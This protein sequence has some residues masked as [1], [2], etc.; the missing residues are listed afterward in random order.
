[1][2]GSPNLIKPPE[3]QIPVTRGIDRHHLRWVEITIWLLAIV[4]GFFYAWANHHYLTNSDAMSYL[5]V[6]EAYLRRDWHAAVNAYWSPLYSW[7]IAL[8]LLIVRP[9]PYWK[10]AVLHLVNFAIYLFALSC[11]SFLIREMLRR[12]RSQSAEILAAG[13]VTLPDWALLTLGYS[14]FIWSSLLLI[15]VPVESPDMLVASFVYLATGIVL[16]IRR[17][18][19]DWLPFF[20]LGMVL[21]FGYLG[22]S[23]M[24]PMALVFV[25]SGILAIGSW[26]RA[27]SRVSITVALFLLLA[28]P[29]VFAISR[30]K[31]RLTTGESGRLN[32]LWAINRVPYF[33][34]QGEEPG[35]GVPRHP[36]RKIFDDPPAYEFGEPVGGTY[37]VW[38][39]P[40]YWYEGSVGHF[41]LRQQLRALVGSVNGYFELFYSRGLQY[42]LLI[43]LVT[44]YLMGRKPRLLL[45]DLTREWSLL[46]P[47]LAGLGLYTLVNVQG[48]YV[49]SFIV[50]LWL[51]L[52]SAVRLPHARDSEKLIKSITLVATISIILTTIMSSTQEAILTGRHL[53]T[54]ENPSVHEQWQVAEGLKEI[55]LG[56]S[57]KVAFVGNSFRAFWA[58]LLG[59]RI[60][61]EIRR[62][63]VD[64]FWQAD[65]SLKGEVINA[66]A[67]T[68]A[69][70]IVFEAPPSGTHLS[71]WQKI[72][73]TNYY[74]YMLKP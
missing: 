37:P 32:Y 44:L 6:A 18:P 23:I 63:R 39:D 67:R 47:A 8:A 56:P 31:D 20:L 58:H 4:L 43:G 27:L 60:V 61:A 35:N 15:T 46:I 41:D 36:T 48:R 62:D 16:R 3:P 55:G 50:L 65:S 2:K 21:G 66:F 57:D 72:R 28:G 25:I 9:S 17:R 51:G 1:L 14:L 42:G 13:L 7:L 26:R 74:V 54:G 40:T 53:T 49:A 5:D 64:S 73:N 11:F 22:K 68:D 24:L 33:H 34:W 10:F 38:Y 30:S 19:S 29:F 71:G 70:A 69:K 12:H 45:S 52:F 59:V